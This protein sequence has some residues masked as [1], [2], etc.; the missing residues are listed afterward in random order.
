M[1]DLRGA[2]KFGEEYG[3]DDLERTDWSGT[4]WGYRDSTEATCPDVRDLLDL[5]RLFKLTNE[6]EKSIKKFNTMMYIYRLKV[7][8]LPGILSG[9]TSI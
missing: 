6:G 5:D 7:A 2:I 3:P 8:K 1:A 9:E 4:Q